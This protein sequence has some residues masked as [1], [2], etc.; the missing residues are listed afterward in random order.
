M[1]SSNFGWR[2]PNERIFLETARL[3]DVAPAECVYVGDTISRDISGARR[4]GYGLAIQ[5]E[6]FLTAK[7]DK[8]TDVAQPDA[9]VRN[10]M[11]IVDLVAC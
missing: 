3:L 7:A 10:L 2:K 6:S 9:V 8:A 1:T 4:A 5:I 11:D